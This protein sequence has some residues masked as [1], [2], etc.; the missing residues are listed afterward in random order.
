[1]RNRLKFQ[2]FLVIFTAFLFCVI[3]PMIFQSKTPEAKQVVA[4]PYTTEEFIK[5]ISR[6]IKPQAE[7]YG[8]RPSLLIGQALLESQNGT[9]LLS[10]KYRNLFALQARTGQES[11]L[12]V[13]SHPLVNAEANSKVRFA[14]YK[15]WQTSIEDYLRRLKSGQVW[16]KELYRKLATQKG[17]K[18]PA[19]TLGEYIYPYDSN[20]SNKLIKIIEDQE[21]TQYD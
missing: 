6:D 16:D 5:V 10:H 14:R 9:S 11:V 7:A 2:V 19:K 13:T 20:Y 3:I 1:M 12:L 21:L 15:D 8:I 18:E 4:S 17:Y